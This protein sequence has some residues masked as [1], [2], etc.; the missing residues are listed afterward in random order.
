M[1][2]IL[3][4]EIFSLED[5]R[6]INYE[7]QLDKHCFLAMNFYGARGYRNNGT[8]VSIPECNAE[9]LRFAASRLGVE[10]KELEQLETIQDT[11]Y[12]DALAEDL[13]NENKPT[14]Q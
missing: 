10:L 1:G 9:N 7:M 13:T 14:E 12:M 3:S 2:C 4:S 5:R 8:K 11:A 6:R